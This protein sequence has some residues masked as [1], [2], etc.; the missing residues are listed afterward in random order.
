MSVVVIDYKGGNTKSVINAIEKLNITVTLSSKR[1]IINSA[2]KVIFPGVGEAK[3]AIQSLANANLINTIKELKVPVLGI[4][5]GLQLL[6]KNTEERNCDCLNIVDDKILKFKV[7]QK[8]PHM[9]WNKIYNIKSDIFKNIKNQEYCYFVHSYYAPLSKYTIATCNYGELE[10][11]AA[12]NFQNFYAVQF[13]P[14]K[15]GKIGSEIIKN[16]LEM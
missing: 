6:F 15:S 9:G 12:I 10:F 5:L 11:S 8:I 2:S 16:F 3:T 1:E 14:E 7:D 13:H 4:C